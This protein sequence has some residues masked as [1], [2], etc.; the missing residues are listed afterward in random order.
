MN[1]I[2]PPQTDDETNADLNPF[3]FLS[4]QVG[5]RGKPF[6]IS[7]WPITHMYDWTRG[8]TVQGRLCFTQ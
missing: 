1:L 7:N 2:L 4:S 5:F 8:Q 6:L 3:F